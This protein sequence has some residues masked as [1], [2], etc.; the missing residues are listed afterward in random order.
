LIAS[1]NGSAI[2]VP[3]PCNMARRENRLLGFMPSSIRS[4]SHLERAALDDTENQARK[5]VVCSG[6]LPADFFHCGGVRAFEAASQ[7]ECQHLHCQI[8]GESIGLRTQ[9]ILQSLD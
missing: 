5:L 7:R 3:I 2:A 4:L 6:R 8:S 9:N 1:R